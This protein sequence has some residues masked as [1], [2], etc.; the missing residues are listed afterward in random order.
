MSAA[1]NRLVSGWRPEKGTNK[2]GR[3]TRAGG[4]VQNVHRR[5]E[6]L[7]AHAV[8]VPEPPQFVSFPDLTTRSGATL[9]SADAVSV[10]GRLAGPVSVELS[11]RG[12]LVVAGPNGAGNSTLLSVLAGQLA[13]DTGVVRVPRGVRLDFLSQE[14]A[15]PPDRRASEVFAAHVSALVTAERLQPQEAV[16]LSQLGL[17]RP[18][19]ASKRVGELSMGQQRRLGLAMAVAVRPHVLILDEPT[20]HLSIALVDELT[21]ALG[22]TQA[23]VVVS[24]HDRQLLRDLSEWPRPE[25]SPT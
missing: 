10:A 20:N 1:Q 21:E 9:L 23:A 7:E 16:G 3:A 4:L 25:L 8:T 13:P 6:A 11:H 12:R 2:H 17:L 18:R 24:T 15:P 14:T 19:E 5:Q 22:T